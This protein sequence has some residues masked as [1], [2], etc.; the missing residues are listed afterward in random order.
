MGCHHCVILCSGCITDSIHFICVMKFCMRLGR[1]DCLYY[2]FSRKIQRVIPRIKVISSQAV[3][4]TLYCLIMKRLRRVGFGKTGAC[5]ATLY[6]NNLSSIH[7]HAH[8]H[9]HSR[10]HARYTR[11][12]P[13]Y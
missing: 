7:T 4:F 12:M 6:A 1:Y 3:I 13:P 11:S 10:A 2:I 9:I 5:Y 8:T